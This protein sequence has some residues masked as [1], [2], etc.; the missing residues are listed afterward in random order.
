[1][2]LDN[3]MLQGLATLAAD[4]SGLRRLTAGVVDGYLQ[5]GSKCSPPSWVVDQRIC[6][7]HG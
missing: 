5:G 4:A 3:R 2:R 6:C 1:V 7:C